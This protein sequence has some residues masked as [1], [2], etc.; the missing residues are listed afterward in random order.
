MRFNW[1]QFCSERGIH[2]VASGPNTAKGNISIKCPYCA[3]DP[4]E[5]LGLSL[6]PARPYWGCWRGRHH[7]GRDPTRLVA[8][9]LHVGIEQA[10]VIVQGQGENPDMFEQ[11]MESLAP[12][13][14]AEIKG[15]SPLTMPKE[16]RK[17]NFASDWRTSIQ[18]RFENYLM[19]ERG[20]GLYYQK[21]ITIYD[22]RWCVTGDYA[23]RIVIP[24]LH[25]GELVAWTARAIGKATVRYR[26]LERE[27]EIRNIKDCLLTPQYTYRRPKSDLLLVTEGPFDAMKL[28]IF[29]AERGAAAVC[30]F[31]L[32]LSNLQL[33]MLGKMMSSYRKVAVLLDAKEDAASG[34]MRDQ[35]EEMW[36]G[37]VVTGKLPSGV[38]DAGALARYQVHL[39]V[40]QLRKH[41]QDWIRPARQH[42]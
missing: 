2:Y 15:K 23:H 24:V 14:E 35:I 39:L 13:E 3:D 28:E 9:L 41:G 10:L 32:T 4:S 6:D 16:F 40:S 29:G 22:L 17:F 38:K 20:F 31:G 34:I 11:A 12:K 36:G 8:K 33:E 19:N 42:G 25:E 18:K 37:E 7:R 27:R 1:R 30:V 26:S 5:H 21:L